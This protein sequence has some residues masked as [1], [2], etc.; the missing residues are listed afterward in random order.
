MDLKY[1]LVTVI[2][3]FAHFTHTMVLAT[4]TRRTL[5]I[6]TRAPVLDR[7]AIATQLIPTPHLLVGLIPRLIAPPLTRI[8][9]RATSTKHTLEVLDHAMTEFYQTTATVILLFVHF[10]HT[11]VLATSTRLTLVFQ[12][13]ALVLDWAATATLLLAPFTHIMINAMSTKRMSEI[14]DHAMT[15]FY[16][17]MATVTVLLVALGTLFVDLAMTT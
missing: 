4:S 16:Q 6:Q 14:L 1:P 7:A 2:L 15:E 13:L 8:T 10:T 5:V 3:G 12:T 9:V 11:M 17:T